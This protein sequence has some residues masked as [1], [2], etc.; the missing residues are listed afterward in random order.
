[1][2]R[3][4]LIYHRGAAT[5]SLHAPGGQSASGAGGA[6]ELVADAR[7]DNRADILAALGLAGPEGALL[8]DAA[9]IL[10]AYERWGENCP[11]HLLGDFAFALWD[12][13]RH[14]I[15]CARDHAGI[16]QLSYYSDARLFACA[17][18]PWQ[19]LDVPGVPAEPD[20]LT[21]A[22]WL[23][24]RFPDPDVTLYRGIRRLPAAHVLIASDSGVELRRYW[25]AADAAPVSRRIDVGPGSGRWSVFPD[26]S[27]R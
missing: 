17:S 5:P 25:D 4:G 7:L 14:R 12:A 9:L 19:L 13:R 2:R 11:A 22:R 20:Q 10:A 1:M 26:R 15:F 21:L 18:A 6:L 8:T 23:L 16:R 27:A 24:D 3:I